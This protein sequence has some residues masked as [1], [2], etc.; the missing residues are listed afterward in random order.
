[1]QKAYSALADR[2]IG[3]LRFRDATASFEVG[4][5]T[6]LPRA[7]HSVAGALA[8]YSLIHF[9]PDQLNGALAEIRRVMVTGGI[10]VV[11]FFEGPRAESVER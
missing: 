7:D 9:D 2:Y 8:W 6:S 10:Q 4:S 3:P 11:G 1:M 5:I